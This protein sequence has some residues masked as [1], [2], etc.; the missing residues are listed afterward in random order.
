MNYIYF[1]AFDIVHACQTA[2]DTRVQMAL[3][4][5]VFCIQPAPVLSRVIK[6]GACDIVLIHKPWYQEPHRP[7]WWEHL[8]VSGAVNS[9]RV[10]Q[11]IPMREQSSTEFE[12]LTQC[13]GLVRFLVYKKRGEITCIETVSQPFQ[14][15]IVKFCKCVQHCPWSYKLKYCFI[16]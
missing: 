1:C 15:L 12:Q 4:A 7:T 16:E 5:V 6:A 14:G 2:V 13:S 3:I 8:F 11:A 9:A 10:Q